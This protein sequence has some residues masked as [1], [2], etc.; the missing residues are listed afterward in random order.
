MPAVMGKLNYLT[1]M[2]IVFSFILAGCSS[3]SQDNNSSGI[4]QPLS[5]AESITGKVAATVNSEEI[6]EQEVSQAMQSVANQGMDM[7]RDEVLERLISQ[8]LLSQEADA[9]APSEGEALAVIKEKLAM[10]NMSLEE[11]RQRLDSMGYSFEDELENIMEQMAVQN[12][13]DSAISI[14]VTEDEMRQFYEGYK[15]Q[16]E[17]E[18]PAYEDI[19]Q[20][21]NDSIRQQKRDRGVQALI[22]KI[23]NNSNIEYR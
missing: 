1:I 22:Q 16:S 10:Q 8:E 11:Y 15:S 7:S 17:G 3:G 19:R 4:S 2:L 14:T 12:F 5:P 18:A 6:T 21:I 20:Q 23:R 9:Y 13:I